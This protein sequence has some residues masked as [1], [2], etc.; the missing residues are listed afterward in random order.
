MTEQE[1]YDG[2]IMSG[3]TDFS[4]VVE[5]LRRHGAGWCV[6]GGMAVNAYVSPV[7][8]ANLDMVVVAA[9]LPP[10]LADLATADF[11][12]KEYPYSVNAQRRA[13]PA[14]RASHRLMVQFSKS[15]R[16]QPF[17]ARAVLRPILGID[18]P[19]ATLE[20]VVQGK[21]WAW[22]DPERRL[23]KHAKDEADLIRLGEVHPKI[24]PLL[25][26]A[27]R[28]ALER[29]QARGLPPE[30]GWDDDESDGTRS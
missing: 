13:G 5:T 14:E 20:D 6:I 28:D 24:R 12:V 29:Q 16:Y 4:F 10:V 22:S 27:L 26:D 23:S 1:I 7:Y 17:V 3:T 15:A 9:D 18:V 21:L 30:D 8:T 25:P 11:R 19:V 2:V